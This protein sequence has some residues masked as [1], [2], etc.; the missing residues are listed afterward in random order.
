MQIIDAQ[1]HVWGSGLPSNKSHIQVTSFT[2]EQA[3]DMMNEAG[4]TAA[5]IH[6]PSWD[7]DSIDMALDAVNKYPGRFAIMG[8]ID[9]SNPESISL[10]PDWKDQNGMLGMRFGFLRGENKNLLHNNE[11]DWFWSAASEYQIPI[12]VLATDSLLILKEV[13]RQYPDLSLTIDHLGGRG[14]NTDLKDDEAMEHM[15]DLLSLSEVPNIAVKATGA[16]GY[17]SEIYPF[18]GMH[19]YLKQIYDHFGP[20]RMFWGTDITKMKCS[21]KECITMFTNEL[22]WLNDRDQTLVMGEAICKWWG[23]SKKD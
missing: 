22:P 14:G 13:A 7:P 15:S 21:W 18:K 3:I 8:S 9:L 4:V 23:W 16:P 17:S 2:A 20:N 1:I 19:K 11:L 5:I 10:M 6:P 12:S